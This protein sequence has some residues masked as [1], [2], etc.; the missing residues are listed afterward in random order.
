MVANQCSILHECYLEIA[1]VKRARFFSLVLYSHPL[2]VIFRS[3]S[4]DF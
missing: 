4:G 2:L 1:F 3:I